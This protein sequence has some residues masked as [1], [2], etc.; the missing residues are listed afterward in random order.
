MASSDVKYIAE[1]CKPLEAA[2][3]AAR[4]VGNVLCL[5]HT[6]IDHRLFIPYPR[7]DALHCPIKCSVSQVFEFVPRSR[8]MIVLSA[9]FSGVAPVCIQEAEEELF[10][11]ICSREKVPNIHPHNYMSLFPKNMFHNNDLFT[12]FN[13]GM[14]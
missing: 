7:T 12:L 8:H 10:L 11:W 5:P 9:S 6:Y 1:F 14:L 4:A 13:A 2:L 3:W